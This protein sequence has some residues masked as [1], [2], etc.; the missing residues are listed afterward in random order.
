MHNTLHS[1][2]HRVTLSVLNMM[3][4]KKRQSRSFTHPHPPTTPTPT[5]THHTHTH[6]FS[7]TTQ[8]FLEKYFWA[9]YSFS[10]FFR[11]KEIFLGVCDFFWEK[12]N[13]FATSDF[14][15]KKQ[16]FEVFWVF[17]QK[18]FLWK[19]FSCETISLKISQNRW[20]NDNLSKNNA[21]DKQTVSFRIKTL[22]IV[23]GI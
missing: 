7:W 17:M 6:P 13:F 22:T 11:N 16:I 12:S 23:K 9:F 5:P 10:G 18:T 3:G 2:I 8:F 1:F 4:V 15:E 19:S 21:A 20:E 14:S